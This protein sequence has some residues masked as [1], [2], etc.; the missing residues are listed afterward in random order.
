MM[1]K[2]VKCDY[3]EELISKKEAHYVNG[4]PYCDI[5]VGEFDFEGED[6]DDDDYDEDDEDDDDDEDEDDD[7][8]DDDDD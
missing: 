5:C 8:D 3:C 1:A 2:Y 6:Y 4:R 7:D